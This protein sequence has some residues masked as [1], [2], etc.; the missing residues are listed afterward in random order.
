MA[1]VPPQ[2]AQSNISKWFETVG[3]PPLDDVLTT[4]TDQRVMIAGIC[5]MGIAVALAFIWTFRSYRHKGQS[6]TVAAE[7][8]RWRFSTSEPTVTLTRATVWTRIRNWT[9]RRKRLRATPVRGIAEIERCHTELVKYIRSQPPDPIGFEHVALWGEFQP[10]I[11]N[12]CRILDEQ[13]IPY[14]EIDPGIIFVGTGKWRTFL[15]RLLAVKDDVGKARL[16]C[17]QMQR[18][19]ACGESAQ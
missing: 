1:G 9:I 12:V 11:V 14:P 13:K 15:A 8:I 18:P 6:F 2:E 10:H 3:L 4:A 16:V 5:L 7:P 19:A 17:G